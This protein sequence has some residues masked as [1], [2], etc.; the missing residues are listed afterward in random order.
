VHGPT[1]VA[2]E[3]YFSLCYYFS[4][5]RVRFGPKTSY[6]LQKS[7]YYHSNTEALVGLMTLEA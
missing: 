4:I 2:S 7:L 5:K 1:L 3:P 6:L